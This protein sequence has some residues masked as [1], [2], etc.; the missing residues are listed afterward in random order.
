MINLRPHHLLCT[1]FYRGNGYSN[2]FV[3]NMNYITSK[4]R[5]DK[6]IE[7]KVVYSTDNIC[8]KCPSLVSENMCRTNDKVNEMDLKI[9]NYFNV[10]AKP[11]NYKEITGAINS[12]MTYDKYLDICDHCQ[13]FGMCASIKLYKEEKREG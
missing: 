8:A 1:Q 4:L 3:K 10:E 11:Y 5:A 13:W 6:D 2:D 7:I 12:Q 9:V